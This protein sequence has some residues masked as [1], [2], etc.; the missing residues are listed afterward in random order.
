MPR[1]FSPPD[2][3]IT[4][5]C[6]RRVMSICFAVQMSA[7]AGLRIISVVKSLDAFQRGDL[8]IS[9]YFGATLLA[10]H[11]GLFLSSLRGHKKMKLKKLRVL[12][13][14]AHIDSPSL[15]MAVLPW[16]KKHTFIDGD[17]TGDDS[18][19]TCNVL[20]HEAV[21]S[22]T[23]DLFVRSD[24]TL[25][26]M[27]VIGIV[28][29]G[30]RIPQ[31]QSE[32]LSAKSL[33]DE[34]VLNRATGLAR[35]YKIVNVL[36]GPGVAEPVIYSP[37]IWGDNIAKAGKALSHLS[38]NRRAALLGLIEM[39]RD[40]QGMPYVSALDWTKKQ[41]EA[42]LLEFAVGVGLLDKTQI[43]TGVGQTRD[44]LTTPHIY[45]ELAAVQGRDVCDRIRLFL[46]SIRHGEYYGQWYT[47]RISD[48]SR[49]LTK[50]LDAGEIG[51]CTAIGRDYELVEKAGIVNVKPST[52]KPGQYVME[53]V[54]EDTVRL[55]RD[56]VINRAPAGF[57]STGVS[58]TCDQNSFVSSEGTRAKL[59]E[60]S[61]RVREAE[62]EMLRQLREM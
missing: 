49:L 39:V 52:Y 25:E 3:G 27:A 57:G 58:L 61:K 22:A 10:G 40:F 45:G 32:I 30:A 6:Q 41:G 29:L 50:L 33:G 35:E 19:I 7:S 55:V 36:E 24:P 4:G 16:L 54:Q 18:E 53:L 2:D 8:T 46:D 26:E 37:L 48:P 51:P 31:L 62:Q 43:S 59:G 12:A 60:P 34:E 23:Y 13:A 56:I 44:F 14:A 47:G 17:S 15:R 9:R 38:P 21:L 28:D 11:A 20:D 5:H 42:D 1:S